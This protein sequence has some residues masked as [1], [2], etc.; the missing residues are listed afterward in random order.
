M[1]GIMAAVGLVIGK[2]LWPVLGD[3]IEKRSLNPTTPSL[4]ELYINNSKIIKLRPGDFVYTKSYHDGNVFYKGPL[5]A[6]Y[7]IRRN[8]TFYD[9]VFKKYFSFQMF[10]FPGITGFDDLLKIAKDKPIECLVN[11]DELASPLYGSQTNPVP[12]FKCII[13]PDSTWQDNY[14]GRAEIIEESNKH[15]KVAVRYHLTYFMPRAEY[16]KMFPDHK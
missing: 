15:Y 3:Y 10:N 4:V 6:A 16:Q 11:A 13:P 14:K 1:I 7:R 8:Y 9:N 12:S 5:F 2:M